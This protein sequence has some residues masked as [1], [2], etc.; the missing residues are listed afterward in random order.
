M[1][2][3]PRRGPRPPSSSRPAA[4]WGCGRRGGRTGSPRF[5]SRSRGSGCCLCDEREVVLHKLRAKW[6]DSNPPLRAVRSFGQI[7][8]NVARRRLAVRHHAVLEVENDCVGVA[9]ERLH[10]FPLAV[11]RDEQPG[12]GLGHCG[13]F[14]ISAVRVHSHTS[15]SRWLK[16]R[17]AQVTMPA[18][19]RD[20]LSRTAMHSLSLRSVSPANTGLGKTNLSY[21][22]FATSVPKVVSCTLTPTI[23]LKVKQLLTSGFLNSVFAAAS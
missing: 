21:P 10:D 11:G 3:A 22:R 2:R 1:R 9:V 16:L 17:C 20:L 6:I 14:W 4:S 13:F 7:L 5:Q 19:G 15:S 23:R 18:L 12:S 8:Q